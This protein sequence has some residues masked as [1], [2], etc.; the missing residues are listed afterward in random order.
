MEDLLRSLWGGFGGHCQKLPRNFSG[1][2]FVWNHLSGPM[3][4]DIA[5]LLLRYPIS[6]DTF[7]WRLPVPQMARSPP[8]LLLSFAQAHLCD[9]PFS[10]ISRD[11]CAIPI[12][13]ST[14]NCDTIATSIARYEKCRCWASK[15]ITRHSPFWGNFL[16]VCFR[17]PGTSQ[18]LLQKSALLTVLDLLSGGIRFCP[19]WYAMKYTMLENWTCS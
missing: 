4:R 11:N 10:Y 16:E 19:L 18:K 15:G 14:Q 17:T 3:S 6:R 12:K 8:P 13:T 1:V 5:I 9:T 2:A 7:S